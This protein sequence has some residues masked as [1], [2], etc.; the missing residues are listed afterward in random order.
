[1]YVAPRGI[2]SADPSVRHQQ[3]FH[4]LGMW[5]GKEKTRRLDVMVFAAKPLARI[6]PLP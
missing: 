4:A 3:G 2:A 6:E 1:M 5:F